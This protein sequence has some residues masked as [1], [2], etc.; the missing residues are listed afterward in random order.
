[1]QDAFYDLADEYGIMIWEEFIFAC[2]LYPTDSDFLANVAGEV[3]DN[4][5]RTQH[6]AALIV[7]SGNN[8]NEASI[9]ENWYG[10]PSADEPTYAS[11][12]SDL[13]FGTVFAVLETIDTSRP[14]LPSS[15]SNG[16]ETGR[17]R[18]LFP[19]V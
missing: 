16:D 4:V 19:V 1:M 11:M 7:W 15:P 10:F 9:A 18:T 13:Y 12:Y 8:E 14:V 3:I 5:K 2:A 6:H 17:N